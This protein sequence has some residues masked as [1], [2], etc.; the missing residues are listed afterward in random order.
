MLSTNL[1]SGY[2]VVINDNSTGMFQIELTP[3]K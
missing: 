1:Y 2:D 3:L